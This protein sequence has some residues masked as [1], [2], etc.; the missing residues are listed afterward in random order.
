MCC[1]DLDTEGREPPALPGHVSADRKTSL[2]IWFVFFFFFPMIGQFPYRH[3]LLAL[4]DVG[5][6]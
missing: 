2:V 5:Y 1:M 3:T 4:P 6:F